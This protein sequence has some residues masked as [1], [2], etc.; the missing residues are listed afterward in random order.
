MA[1][2]L[3]RFKL[4]DEMS[5]KLGSMAEKGQSM[6]EQW[7]RAG[8]AANA[9]LE[10]IAGGVSTAVSSVDGIATS[11]DN[12][13]AAMGQADYWTD[14]VGNY[15][16]E[17][18][19]ATYSTEELVE[20]GLKSADALE[21]QNRMLELCEQSASEL[22]RSMDA[23]A[24]I[25]QDLS[26]AMDEAAQTADR[27]AD[28]EDVSAETK[29]ALAKASTEAAEAM[30]ELEKA[31]QEA[32][33]ALEAYNQTMAS[34]TSDL[35][36]LEAAAERA[37]HA[38]ENLAEANGRASE[39]TEEL[40]NAS[41]QAAEEAEG[42]GNK[43][44]DAIGAVAGALAAAG[45]TAKVM[46]IAGAVYELAGSFSEA[47][48]TIVGATGATGRELD[49]LMSNSLDVYASSSAENLNEVAAGMMNV[50]TA[51]GLTGDALEEATDAALVLNNVLGYE[52]SESS[53]TA[54]ALMKNF[55][56][57][58]QEA[59]NLI[60]IG[61]Q[62]GADKNGDLLDVLNEY[63]AQY[64]ALGL[65]AEEFVSSLVDGAEAGVFSV[66][67]V[68][69]AVKEFNIRAKDGSDTTAE[70]FELLGMNADVMS[71]KFAAGGDTARTAFF[72]VVNALES[73]DDPMAKNAAAVGLFGTQYEDLEA[74]VLPVLSGIEGGT[75]DM[76][77]AVG[78]LAE[79]AQSMGDE[80]QAAGNSI[81]AAFGAAITPAV[82]AG[83]S[84][85]AGFV[86]GVGEFLQEHPA[87]TKAI[88]A[89]G[90][91]LG[92][93]VAGFALYAAG[94]AVAT[95]ATALFGTTLSAAI[96]PITAIAAAIAA[97]TAAALFLVDAF[98]EDLGEVEGLTATTREQY[99]ELQDLNAEYE[100][101]CEKY[102]ETSEEALRLKYQV[103]DLTAS[104]E[105]NKQTVEE[106]TAEV[107]ALVQSHDE[108]ISSYEEGMA[109]IDQNEV[110][111]LSLIQKLEDLASTTNRT[112][113]QEEQ[114]KAVI[115]QLNTDLPELA[116]SYDDVASSTEKSIEA[117]KQA[118]EAQAEQERQAEQKQAYVD[119]LK[120]QANLEEE[121]AK[122]EENVRLEQERMDNMSGW[123]HFWT[124]GEWDDLEAYQA[125][126]DELNAAY[127][128][129][130]AALQGIED[131]WAG[132][133]EA[134]EEAAE[135]PS[136]YEEA[137]SIAY[138]NVRAKVEE[139]CAAY[140]EAYQA[141][142]ESFEGQFGLFDE[143]EADMDA[144]VANA[145]AALDSQLAYW[146]SYSANVETLKN[147]SAEDLGV[148]QENYEALMAY[149]QSGSEEAAGLAASMA[150]AINSGNTEAV[151]ALAE[152]VGQVQAAKETA[153]AAVA[154]WQ[155]DFTA[156]MN[157][158]EQEMQ[159]TINGMDLS[160]EAS[161][162][163]SSTINSYANQIR[164]GKNGAVSAAREVASAVTS[165]LS[166]ANAT[167]HV[168]VTS[169]GSVAGHA[170]GTTN[171]ESVFL[172]GEQGPELVAR[173]AAAYASGT[174]DSTD[175][176]IAG[177]NGPELIVGEQGSTV[178]P[179][180]ETDR[181]IAALNEK[182]QPLQVFTSGGGSETSSG[183]ET[184]QEQV[185]RILLEIAGSGAI[186]VSGNGAD[187]ETVLQIMWE[188]LKPILM[189]II[190]SEIYE[191]GD[192]SYEY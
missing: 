178:F 176:F 74:T 141:A 15:S 184:A 2:L 58:A 185:K 37:G 49:E 157:A 122:A 170:K 172:A 100:E 109:T 174:T 108:L 77:D 125:A 94:T 110:G 65:S 114:M 22:G 177:E 111:T 148:T 155:T 159:D 56:V 179:T 181:L 75:L 192:M 21:E 38:A 187:R 131:D 92:V 34:G 12:L 28:N 144:T 45:I 82:S 133:A 61:A 8:D 138:E 53:R 81:K 29:Q 91:G 87:V 1:D 64:S 142:L 41:E 127:A 112:A 73:M 151:A 153:A 19:E 27:L 106:F 20:M 5:D 86:Q 118:A 57:S 24:Q 149:A 33:E 107:D 120:E 152:T 66:D 145:Q 85:L 158:I 115:D 35:N 70:A 173:P 7:E 163:A 189:S 6:T 84:A 60:A 117:M 102:G 10:G 13:Q 32:D 183:R 104:Y 25:Q 96:W 18:L 169:S 130:Q 90:V 129:N 164:A 124:G 76:Y 121:I 119:L 88:T 16:R 101:A 166:S 72:E 3:A 48:K 186:E 83:S 99:Y 167:I 31:Q 17:L 54:G 42:A 165:A 147:T 9:A 128:E 26:A 190:Q 191:E 162:A 175:Y 62:N 55:G 14:A 4:V 139:L 134:A 89:I 105:A 161:A 80:W 93:V 146:E 68:G 52:V 113:A 132:V 116:L 78:T 71:E 40:S 188:N 182:R 43:G 69:D 143:A 160:E 171:A 136:S 135:S 150:E 79:G 154:D 140:D 50:K 97:V 39:A 123:D 103:D 30:R 156:Q 36:Q 47:E 98:Q 63:S 11:I 126:L 180:Q 46:E 51:T 67:K 59:Y 168:N 23:T 95:A 44:T 137:V